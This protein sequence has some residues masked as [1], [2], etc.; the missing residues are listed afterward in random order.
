M[1][2]GGCGSEGA[3]ICVQGGFGLGFLALKAGTQVC[4]TLRADT[5]DGEWSGGGAGDHTFWFGQMVSEMLGRVWS[6][7]ITPPPR[8]QP[9][10]PQNQTREVGSPH[11][12]ST[13]IFT[14]RY[15]PAPALAHTRGRVL[16]GGVRRASSRRG[17][18]SFLFAFSASPEVVRG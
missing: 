11:L 6:C 10:R 4:H 15:T 18:V 12:A 8:L 5:Q 2:G 1:C 14:P 3:A 17:G 13:R 7:P 9:H 16:A